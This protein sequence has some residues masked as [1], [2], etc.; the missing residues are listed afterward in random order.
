M[1]VSAVAAMM[2]L[3]LAGAG[4]ASASVAP[5]PTN[6]LDCNAWSASYSSTRPAQKAL[7]TDPI[8]VLNGKGHPVPR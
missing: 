8:A 6:D 3:V 1:G 2:A 4:A 7:C 5:N